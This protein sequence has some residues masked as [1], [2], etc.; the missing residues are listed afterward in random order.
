MNPAK[1]ENDEYAGLGEVIAFWVVGSSIIFEAVSCYLREGLYDGAIFAGTIGEF[2]IAADLGS[3][4]AAA[5]N[6]RSGYLRD[7]SWRYGDAETRRRIVSHCGASRTTRGRK[8]CCS[9][10][11]IGFS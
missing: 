8:P 11:E 1:W 4:Q 5:G 2:D 7:A 3:A 9:Q 6:V 10:S